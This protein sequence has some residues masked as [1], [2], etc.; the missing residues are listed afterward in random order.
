[1]SPV[2]QQLVTSSIIVQL[3]NHWGYLAYDMREEMGKMRR[4]ILVK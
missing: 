2:R 4:V 3:L 1:M